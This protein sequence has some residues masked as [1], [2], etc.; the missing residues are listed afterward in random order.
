M[1]N[2]NDGDNNNNDEKWLSSH[3]SRS[4]YDNTRRLISPSPGAFT[5]TKNAKAV[6]D[7]QQ[8]LKQLSATPR[9]PSATNS[10]FYIYFVFLNL[11]FG[12]LLCSFFSPCLCLS[13]LVL[14]LILFIQLPRRCSYPQGLVLVL[15]DKTKL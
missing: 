6:E 3:A 15:N 5:C 11:F 8:P 14:N 1:K 10:T 2:N 9:T 7:E 4:E 12:K 13:C